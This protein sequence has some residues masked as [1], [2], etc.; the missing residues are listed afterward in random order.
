MSVHRSTWS[1]KPLV[2]AVLAI[3]SIPAFPTTLGIPP[4]RESLARVW[5]ACS[6]PAVEGARLELDES[7]SGNLVVSFAPGKT[8]QAY[9]I[10]RTHIDLHKLR[11]EAIALDHDPDGFLIT[12]NATKDLVTLQLRGTTGTAK[13]L[14]LE[15]T[16]VP[17]DQIMKTIHA[18][19]KR[20]N[21]L[22]KNQTSR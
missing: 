9:R 18:L 21:S 17:Y 10:G 15:F 12:G 22:S 7:G 4:S 20:A 14:V 13:G 11:F 3:M 19:D 8:T 5:L 2:W 1:T 16:L 6:N